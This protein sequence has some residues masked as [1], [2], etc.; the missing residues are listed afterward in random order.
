[1]SLK[2][3]YVMLN[4]VTQRLWTIQRI[5]NTVLS[6]ITSTRL[7]EV[8]IDIC[9]DSLEQAQTAITET[10]ER[11]NTPDSTFAFHSILSRSIFASLPYVGGHQGVH[12]KVSF[13]TDELP[14]SIPGRKRKLF[15][16]AIKF[17]ML[18]LF[19]PWLD[20]G[21]LELRFWPDPDGEE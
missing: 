19:A 13:T 8:W 16:L 15:M 4:H 17:H 1:M 10:F 18:A 12:I 3:L 9:L 14:W 5:L 20:R 11:A 21:V 7:E 2:R 6:D